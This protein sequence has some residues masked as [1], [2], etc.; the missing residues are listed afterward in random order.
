MKYKELKE[1][2]RKFNPTL[3]IGYFSI[4]NHPNI[5]NYLQE[6]IYDLSPSLSEYEREPEY[7]KGF[8]TAKMMEPY[9]DIKPK[10]A[11]LNNELEDHYHSG[12]DK[13]GKSDAFMD[14]SVGSGDLNK[15]L[16]YHH[17]KKTTP[18]Q[19]KSYSNYVRTMDNNIDNYTKPAPKDFHVYTGVGP[20]LDILSH[21]NNRSNRL[22]LPAFTSTSLQ[23]S[24]A[25]MFSGRFSDHGGEDKKYRE[26]VR[27]HIPQGSTHG[28]YLGS[29][30]LNNSLG[31]EH[32]FLLHRG[33]VIQFIG[34][35]RM[36]TLSSP[37][38]VHDAKIIRQ[39]RKPI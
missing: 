21:R 7:F 34:E 13:Q 10:V 1:N 18:N 19:I 29:T 20:D 8:Y 28:T 16:I 27:L 15:F 22:Y 14:Y 33:H 9:Y 5:G 36:S 2:L 17:L 38:L 31:H 30:G 24:T 12:F 3:H 32:E 6:S 4:G 37:I 11:A 35:P 26:V 23:P 39:I 25:A